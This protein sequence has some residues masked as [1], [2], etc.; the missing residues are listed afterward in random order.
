MKKST[1]NNNKSLESNNE[2]SNSETV[3]LSKELTAEPVED[4]SSST[5]NIEGEQVLVKKRLSKTNYAMLTTHAI[6]NIASVFVSTFL[7]SYIYKISNNYVLNI[8]LFYL[9]NY[10]VMSIFYYLVSKI[11]DRTIELSSIK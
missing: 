7:I 10:L 1:K 3:E 11:L 9:M 2:T 5:K 4:E 6:N 8:G